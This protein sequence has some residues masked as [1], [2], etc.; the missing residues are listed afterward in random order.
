LIISLKDLTDYA[1]DRNFDAAME[2]YKDQTLWERKDRFFSLFL[3]VCYK[4][5]HL[6]HAVHIFNEMAVANI[7]P[8]EP[9]Y[10][11]LIR[12]NTDNNDIE[13]SLGLIKHMIELEI[14][15]KLRTFHPI[16]EAMC[17]K[18]KDIHQAVELVQHMQKLGVIL[19]SE[20]LTLLLECA[21]HT[22]ALK[23]PKMLKEFEDI[24]ETT[25]KELLGMESTEMKHIS[26][27]FNEISSEKVNDLGILVQSKEDIVGDIIQNDT[28]INGSVIALNDSYINTQ[29]AFTD[30]LSSPV[31]SDPTLPIVGNSVLDN[32]VKINEKYI[33]IDEA[34]KEAGPPL[35]AR[36]VD[37]SNNTCLCP[38]C[39][40]KIMPL[41][42]NEDERH[43]VR[44]A[45]MKIASLA[46]LQQCKNLQAFDQW[47]K[48]RDEFIHI[49]DG[50]NVAYAKQNFQID[51][52]NY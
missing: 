10:L 34:G 50:A 43:R 39:G 27:V 49:V 41:L 6:P 35:P 30:T 9:S 14:E 20:Q 15:P 40:D 26:S 38:N 4:A 3:S 25:S 31:T 8:S 16:L 42:L 48:E 23:D 52:A 19:R 5:E 1:K 28:L 36:I 22:K 46:S 13:T 37:I 24:M 7:A 44:V 21:Y 12:C 45:L 47:L 32:V 17:S 2:I 29:T 18:R 51:C 33:I 11:A